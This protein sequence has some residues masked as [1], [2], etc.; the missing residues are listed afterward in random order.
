MARLRGIAAAAGIDLILSA[1][2]YALVH[3]VAGLLILAGGGFM[4]I[5]L[6]TIRYYQV[7]RMESEQCL[8]A[9]CHGIRDDASQLL[10]GLSRAFPDPFSP[11]GYGSQEHGDDGGWPCG[12][13][14]VAITHPECS[15]HVRPS[16]YYSETM[17]DSR[18]IFAMQSL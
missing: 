5:L 1:I 9:L 17:T 15:G 7:Q 6:L 11:A 16:C 18:L 10:T 12:Q 2:F 3:W 8:H 14:L 13:I 4:V